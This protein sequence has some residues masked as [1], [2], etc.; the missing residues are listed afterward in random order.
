[1]KEQ[2]LSA[3]EE[4]IFASY[5]KNLFEKCHQRCNIKRFLDDLAMKRGRELESSLDELET[6]TA[7]CISLT[8]D[9]PHVTTDEI[10]RWEVDIQEA[11]KKARDIEG[12]GDS[13]EAM[14]ST[15]RQLLLDTLTEISRVAPSSDREFHNGNDLYCSHQRSTIRK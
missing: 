3:A 11:V 9:S 4:D 10:D 5:T 13:E 1:M 8:V 2:K 14:W 15:Y 7:I 12:V 6:L